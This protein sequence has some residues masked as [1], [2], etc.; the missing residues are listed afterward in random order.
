MERTVSF[1]L[2]YTSECI[3]DVEYNC[4]YPN[5]IPYKL[6]KLVKKKKSTQ[7]SGIKKN[8]NSSGLFFYGSFIKSFSQSVSLYYL[9]QEY[10][11][12]Y[13]HFHFHIF[14]KKLFHK[15]MSIDIDC[16]FIEST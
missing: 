14:Y 6:R 3:K 7:Y 5:S 16:D 13:Y 10:S 4:N 11:G 9:H 15:E 2:V 1:K 12:F 8:Q